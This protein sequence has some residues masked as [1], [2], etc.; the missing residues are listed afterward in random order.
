MCRL[1]DARSFWQTILVNCMQLHGKQEQWIQHT[2]FLA[3][4]LG[5]RNDA[6]DLDTSF[7]AITGS[8]QHYHFHRSLVAHIT[9]SSSDFFFFFFFLFH[10]TPHCNHMWLTA[11][12][13]PLP[14]PSILLPWGLYLKAIFTS[15]ALLMW[16]A[17]K[18]FPARAQQASVPCLKWFESST[19]ENCGSN[20]NP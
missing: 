5:Y 14:E 11:A 16:R 13:M 7:C 15:S 19:E 2:D 8:D 6:S 9:W 4:V 3:P 10:C 12:S 20:A 1:L 18:M 17:T